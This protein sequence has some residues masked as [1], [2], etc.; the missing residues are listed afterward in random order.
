MILPDSNLLLHAYNSE[1]ASHA[2]ARAWW[3]ELMNGA[4]PVGL[5]WAAMLGFIRLSTH[6]QALRHPMPVGT[7]CKHVRSWLAQP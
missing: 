4:D 1:S 3:E 2:R 5:S 7:A 6:R